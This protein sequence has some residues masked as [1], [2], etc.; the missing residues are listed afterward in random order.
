MHRVSLKSPINGVPKEV[1]IIPFGRHE[2][3]KGTFVLDEEGASAVIADFNARRNDM[4]IDYEHQTLG[5]GEAP[6]AGWINRLINKGA[7]GV[8]AVVAWTPRAMEYLRNREYRY[9]SPVF[10]KSIS[11]GRVVRLVNAALTNQP[12]IDGMVPVVNKGATVPP[13][14]S[15]TKEARMKKLLELLGLKEDATEEQVVEAVTALQAMTAKV[16]EILVIG[17]G[18]DIVPAIQ[19]MKDMA[20]VV[21]AKE[22]I[23]ALGLKDGA[24]LSEVTGTITAMKAAGGHT[25]D[26]ATEVA[27]LREK[28]AV[29]EVREL[30]EAAMKEGK[31]APAQGDWALEYAGRD[32]EGFKAF[33]AK[34]PKVVP[35][36]EAAGG[37]LPEGGVATDA[38]QE[39]VNK[40]LGVDEETFKKHN[41]KE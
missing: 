5:D 23:E 9:L 41:A 22:V 35:T 33:A 8:W 19:A 13:D 21:A 16:R 25:E 7:Q 28:L 24:T 20:T 18:E 30:V 2:T 10:L 4:V 38:L 26:L 29:R 34:A 3:S 11:D 12:A 40:S 15:Q 6:A 39:Q 31:I 17:E 36:G 27:T 32:P 37:T 1:Q 14:K